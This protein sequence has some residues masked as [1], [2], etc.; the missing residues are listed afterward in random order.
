MP[1][2]ITFS[3]GFWSAL[4]GI[5]LLYYLIVLAVLYGPFFLAKRK[6]RLQVHFTPPEN[7]PLCRAFQEYAKIHAGLDPP[8][9]KKGKLLIPSHIQLDMLAK[10]PFC[11]VVERENA[12]PSQHDKQPI[13]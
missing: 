12:K 7:E 1:E 2:W 3:P 13:Q 5:L 11:Q 6:K 10:E 4:A 8:R 9:F